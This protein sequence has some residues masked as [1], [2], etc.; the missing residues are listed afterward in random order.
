MTAPALQ[1]PKG[2]RSREA[3][4]GSPVPYTSSEL[5]GPGVKAVVYGLEK[6][7]Q[8]ESRPLPSPLKASLG[9][10]ET[11]QEATAGHREEGRRLVGE[12]ALGLLVAEYTGVSE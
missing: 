5:A 4:R 8:S 1:G 10:A 11:G 7:G 9:M 3:W 12:V 6:E 2:P